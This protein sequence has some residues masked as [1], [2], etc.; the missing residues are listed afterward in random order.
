[1]KSHYGLAKQVLRYLK[2]THNRGLKFAKG[3]QLKLEQGGI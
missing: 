1:M 3:T 2:G